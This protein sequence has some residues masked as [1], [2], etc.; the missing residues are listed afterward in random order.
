MGLS[1]QM[2]E[3]DDALCALIADQGFWVT[4]FDNRDVGLSTKLDRLG[5]PNLIALVTGSGVP[6]YALDDM[7]DDAAA[8][9]DV[10]GIAAAHVVGLSMGGM[11]AQ[12]IA[13]NHPDRVLSLTSIMSTVGG[14][15]VIQA[16][17][18]AAAA[19]VTPPARPATSASRTRSPIAGS[20]SPRA[21]RSTRSRACKAE[22]ASRPLLLPRRRDAA[23]GGGRRGPGQD[24]TSGTPRRPDAG[25]PTARRIPW[26]RRATDCRLR[27][28]FPA[29]G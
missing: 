20:S 19:L 7:A 10:L 17:P 14:P 22:R 6:P 25:D 26:S 3:W 5:P 21:C 29:R 13:I 27:R 9:L 23:A 16:Q 1:Y 12:L 28:P 24:R 4:R 18:A 11:I 15:N 2:I 8:L